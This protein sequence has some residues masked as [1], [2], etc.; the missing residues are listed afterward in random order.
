MIYI[1]LHNSGTKLKR[2]RKND[3]SSTHLSHDLTET[4]H[5]MWIFKNQYKSVYN[6]NACSFILFI[7]SA[8]TGGTQQLGN[9][10]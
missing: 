10:R 5:L 1:N 8:N 6:I 4:H 7:H 2:Q 3:K 9:R